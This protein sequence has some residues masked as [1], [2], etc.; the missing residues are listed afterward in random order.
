MSN[1]NTPLIIRL[2]IGL[3]IGI[4]VAYKMRNVIRAT[5]IRFIPIRK[6]ISQQS[7]ELQTRLTPLIC[8]I[9]IAVVTFC[10]NHF[11]E[12][13]IN[14]IYSIDQTPDTN[15]SST[16]EQSLFNT[17]PEP[18]PEVRTIPKKQSVK[19]EKPARQPSYTPTIDAT[20]KRP[21]I[22][23]EQPARLITNPYY[24]QRDAFSTIDK[25]NRQ[26]SDYLRS[27]HTHQYLIGIDP[28]GDIPYKLLI[29][30]FPNREAANRYRRH[31]RILGFVRR[32][33]TLQLLSNN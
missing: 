28:V 6:R 12:K 5:I 25:A 9:L 24:I 1:F 30:P 27:N 11:I 29:G 26:Y 17:N 23:I 3:V 22:V 20:P 19:I 15:Q 21:E 33:E 16:Y 8:F 14:K 2:T 13:G 4:W 10:F 18:I 31:Y 32:G 7:Y